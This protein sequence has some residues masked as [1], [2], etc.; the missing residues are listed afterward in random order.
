M[1][2]R[3]HSILSLNLWIQPYVLNRGGRRT[4]QSE[5]PEEQVLRFPPAHRYK[6]DTGHHMYERENVQDSSIN[7]IEY[8][9]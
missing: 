2:A 8:L 5:A 1:V 3:A 7:A 4:A 6:Q 9:G